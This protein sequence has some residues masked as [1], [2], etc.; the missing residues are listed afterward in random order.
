MLPDLVCI[1]PLSREK[2]VATIKKDISQNVGDVQHS[3]KKSNVASSQRCM[4]HLPDLR[5]I[6]NS[7]QGADGRYPYKVTV[8][9]GLPLYQLPDFRLHRASLHTDLGINTHRL[10]EVGHCFLGLAGGM[11]EVCQIVVQGCLAMAISQGGA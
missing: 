4:Q 8:P 1:H 6:S 9:G 10:L 3:I 2:R 5:I 11:Q 7:V